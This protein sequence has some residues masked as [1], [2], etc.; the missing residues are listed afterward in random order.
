MLSEGKNRFRNILRKTWKKDKIHKW[1][2]FGGRTLRNFVLFQVWADQRLFL[3]LKSCHPSW[4]I[5]RPVIMLM[6]SCLPLLYANICLSS[7]IN[8]AWITTLQLLLFYLALWSRVVL[9]LNR[10]ASSS[11]FLQTRY[12]IFPLVHITE[13]E[14]PFTAVKGINVHACA[15]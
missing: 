11:F 14:V 9:G 12:G 10:Q 8:L 4:G 7:L 13:G 3:L 2:Y 6:V 1:V 5:R 15:P